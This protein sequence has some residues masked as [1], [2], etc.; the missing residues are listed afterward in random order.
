MT[1]AKDKEE[2]FGNLREQ[3]I[4]LD[5]VVEALIIKHGKIVLPKDQSV[6]NALK[7]R[8]ATVLMPKDI[9]DVEQTSEIWDRIYE[10]IL[11]MQNYALM[12][13]GDVFRLVAVKDARNM[14]K[15]IIVDEDGHMLNEKS[16]RIVTKV[17]RLKH[18]SNQSVAMLNN[19]ISRVTPP[20]RLGDNKT[21]VV[22]A[23]E[24]EIKYYEDILKLFD[25]PSEV[26]YLKTYTLERAIPTQVKTHVERFIASMQSSRAGGTK[27]V[28][29]K[30]IVIADDTTG[31]MLVS[32]IEEDHQVTQTLVD[33]FDQDVAETTTFR[34]IEMIRLSNAKAE[35]ISKTLDQV[36]KSRRSSAS[37]RDP[38]AK[39]EDIPTIVPFEQLNA[40]IVS[41]EQP[42]TFRYVKEVIQMLDVKRKQVYLSSTIVEVRN[43]N[44]FEFGTSLGLGKLPTKS[45]NFGTIVGSGTSGSE[46]AVV[47]VDTTNNSRGI[48][49]DPNLTSGLTASLLY[50]SEDFIPLVIRAA[51]TN[52]NVTIIATPSIVCDDNE[53]AVIE[54]TEQRQFNTT[55]T[56]SNTTN[57]TF[58]GFNDAGKILDITPTISSNNF[59]KLE[60]TINYDRFTSDP[61]QD[62]VRLKRKATTTVTIPNGTSVVIGGLTDSDIQNAQRGV[63]LLHKIPILGNLFKTKADINNSQT[64]YF[65]ITPEI[66]NNFDDLGDIT[67]RLYENIEGDADEKTRSHR[68]FKAIDNR[69]DD[70]VSEAQPVEAQNPLPL[71]K[72]VFTEASLDKW[73]KRDQAQNLSYAIIEGRDQHAPNELLPQYTSNFFDESHLEPVFVETLTK[74]RNQLQLFPPERQMEIVGAFH[75]HLVNELTKV[76][77]AANVIPTPSEN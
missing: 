2:I 24:A 48:S 52:S 60:L 62:Q 46:A 68:D 1:G 23:S 3:E 6:W 31:R 7:S 30:A 38:K 43:D 5:A 25:V 20:I 22:T 59:L 72:S 37:A 77:D 19:Y 27:K 42:E 28:T 12:K 61:G 21:L 70:S 34:P 40:L 69:K 32:A 4:S 57:Q 29:A 11:A 71:L 75:L 14:V 18:I 63:P 44:K 76:H 35:E 64:I 8:K 36:L 41:V 39:K 73:V 33:F 67:N 45:N 10:S 53:Q 65:F 47:T 17:I 51:E 49:L 55:T 13:V 9:E 74:A 54:I 15:P 16:E 50:G 26:P 56:N 66:I 58:G